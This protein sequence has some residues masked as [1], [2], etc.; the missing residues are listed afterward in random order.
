MWKNCCVL[1]G[2]THQQPLAEDDE[3]DAG[4]E[5]GEMRRQEARAHDQPRAGYEQAHEEALHLRRKLAG[6]CSARGAGAC[7]VWMLC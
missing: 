5:D 4:G 2:T 1:Q 6:Q 3:E 7:L